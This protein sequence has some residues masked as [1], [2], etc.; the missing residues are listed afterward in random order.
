VGSNTDVTAGEGDSEG[1]SEAEDDAETASALPLITRW[2][3]FYGV[4][5]RA[6]LVARPKTKLEGV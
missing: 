4:G 6:S 5:V 3:S 1:D 2:A